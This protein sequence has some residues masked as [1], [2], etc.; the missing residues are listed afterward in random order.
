MNVPRSL[1]VWT[2]VLGWVLPAVLSTAA[3][4]TT[5]AETTDYVAMGDS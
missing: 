3:A 4:E 1:A 5:D 2:S